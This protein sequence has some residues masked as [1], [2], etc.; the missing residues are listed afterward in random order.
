MSSA[1]QFSGTIAPARPRS[2]QLR[3]WRQSWIRA[4]SLY[5]QAMD[6]GNSLL[7]QQAARQAGDDQ[8]CTY[9][10]LL[11]LRARIQLRLN[12]F[13]QASEWVSLGLEIKQQSA[14]LL[15]T[16]GLIALEQHHLDQA[17][18]FFRRASRIS[19]VITRAPAYLAHVHWLQGRKVEAFSEYRELFRQTPDDDLLRSRLLMAAAAVT[20]DE[21]RPDL[22]TDLC[23]YLAIPDID[24]SQLH[25]LVAS[26]L[27]Q[28][29][30]LLKQN[31]QLTIENLAAEPL[32][33]AALNH[34]LIADAA[35]ERL[36]TELRSSIFNACVS[37][38]TLPI[39]LM[40]LVQAL[41]NQSFLNEGCWTESR[42]ETALLQ[43]LELLALKLL[44]LPDSAS[45]AST[46]AAVVAL[47][48]MYRQLTRTAVGDALVLMRPKIAAWPSEVA[49]TIHQQLQ[50]Q[51][52]LQACA[53]TIPSFAVIQDPVS[54]QVR[55]QYEAHP[56][57]RW[58]D[59]GTW[60]ISDYQHTL[61]RH[62]PQ[63][64]AQWKPMERP[65]R[66]LVAG[67][68]TGRHALRLARYF[69][70]LAV[71]AVDLSLAAL[72]WGKLQSERL[73]CQL[74]WYQGDLLAIQQLGQ[75]FDVIECSGVLHHMD[76]PLAGLQALADVLK[77]GGVIK[78]ALYS[79][80]ARQTITRLRQRLPQLPGNDAELRQLRA[81]ILEREGEPEWTTVLESADFYSLSACRDLLCHT[82]EHVFDIQG[83]PAWLNKAGLQWV[84]MLAPEKFQQL[85]T[86]DWSA[87]AWAQAE[88]VM[89]DL[90]AGMYQFYAIKMP[91]GCQ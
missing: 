42:R 68:G 15:Y 62:F 66:V 30:S 61:K 72:A 17:E 91:T 14:S 52:D 56:Y 73:Q 64:L 86:S 25:G 65:L 22:A 76:N 36:F 12:H 31:Q 77:P 29:I 19:R 28:R 44:Q 82:H 80:S 43:S 5:R 4:A 67:C 6:S 90:F 24:T 59:P 49:A 2:E 81:D 9:V 37:N 48:C 7:L 13:E 20:A 50:Q 88:K 55:E 89:P 60:Q 53:A 71:T 54:C 32:V 11:N 10:P 46:I 26:T 63:A 45:Q 39:T 35:L 40:P 51:Q 34:L 78:I 75:T 16:G 23:T 70:P 1:L 79:R 85:P 84:G 47:L 18:D 83:I 21:Y 3:F 27:K 41:A 8:D 38:L 74:D 69:T 57:P 58:H 33:V 87:A